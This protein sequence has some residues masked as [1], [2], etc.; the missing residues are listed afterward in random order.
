MLIYRG[1][2]KIYSHENLE[3]LKHLIE[4]D[5]DESTANSSN[6]YFSY[7]LDKYLISSGVADILD[8]I[9]CGITIVI[10]IFYIISTYSTSADING[11]NSTINTIE[12]FLCIYL[13]AHF[14][15]KLYV[16]QDRLYFFF[17]FDSISD[18]GTFI[19]ILLVK[20]DFLGKGSLS[21]YLRL[22]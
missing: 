10:I 18:F 22:L 4:N 8:L 21:Y 6:S 2:N 17:S 7:K 12:I 16:S 20:N 11:I 15:L 9:N 14:T 13:I 5:Y 19:P 1:L 3:K